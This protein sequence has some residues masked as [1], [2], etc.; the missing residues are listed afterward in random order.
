M[1]KNKYD[2]KLYMG[3]NDYLKS[4]NLNY[5]LKVLKL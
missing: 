4:E 1:K 2:F 5:F 3:V